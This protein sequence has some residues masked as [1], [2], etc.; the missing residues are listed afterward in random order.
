MSRAGIRSCRQCAVSLRNLKAA[1][2]AA[3]VARLAAPGVAARET[4]PGVTP[5]LVVDAEGVVD[6]VGGA[7]HPPALG[8][9]PWVGGS[10]QA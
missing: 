9:V 4:A 2:L 6:L 7:A 3:V 5:A 8:V 1:A 10:C